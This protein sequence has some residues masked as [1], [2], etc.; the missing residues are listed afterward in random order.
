MTDC[1]AT[2]NIYLPLSPEPAAKKIISE[3]KILIGKETILLV[4]DEPMVLNVA[5]SM[6]EKLG[7]D[8]LVSD[9]GPE[10]I[11]LVEKGGETFDLVILDLIMPG[12]D[13][14]KTFDHIR[15]LQPDLPV[16]L[17][18]G[19]S[20]NG[21]ALDI[22]NRGCNGFIQKPF[23]LSRLSEKIRKILDTTKTNNP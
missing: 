16:L 2:F 7:Y 19:Y 20:L 21:Y 12:M 22:I 6:L 5:K 9:N 8:V 3:E 4:D 18:S 10:A 15:N 23:N 1:G 17:S 14:G 13:G 11:A